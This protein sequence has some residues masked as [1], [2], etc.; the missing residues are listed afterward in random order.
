MS[1]DEYESINRLQDEVL[2]VVSSVDDAWSLTGGTALSRFYTYHRHSVNLAFITYEGDEAFEDL[3]RQ[4][5]PKL[6]QHFADMRKS[7]DQKGFRRIVVSK[8]HNSLEVDFISGRADP[9]GG[10]QRVD[11]WLIDSVRNIGSNTLVALVTRNEARDAADLLAISRRYV[12]NWSDLIDEAQAT[13]CFTHAQLL[14]R[15]R[16]FRVGSLDEVEFKAPRDSERDANDW[17]QIC[18]HIENLTDNRVCDAEAEPL[19]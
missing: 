5:L 19:K 10:S 12:F 9:G 17:E 1:S 2:D 16:D 11:D 8:E 4:T 18:E 6:Q 7:E 15:C 3:I 13:S 14:Q